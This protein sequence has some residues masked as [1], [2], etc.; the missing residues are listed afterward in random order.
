M[1][2]FASYLALFTCTMMIQPTSWHFT[3]KKFT[4][5]LRSS[6]SCNLWW[7]VFW[8]QHA[9][10]TLMHV[11]ERTY[12]WDAFGRKAGTRFF[13]TWVTLVHK[14][15]GLKPIK[16]LYQKMESE[17]K[18]EYGDSFNEVEHSSFI[19][20][21]FLSYGGVGWETMVVVEKLADANARK[22]NESYSCVIGWMQ[23]C[24]AFSLARLA[25]C[26]IRRSRSFSFCLCYRGLSW[27]MFYNKKN[28]TQLMHWDKSMC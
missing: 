25:I 9:P 26:C 4:M 28:S 23:C 2:R 19:P 3:W 17:K 14:V 13:D 12:K 16:S 5:M 8:T 1:H 18:T 7:G 22:R 24:L 10:P 27:V 21:I 15:I 20:I 11:P 6:W